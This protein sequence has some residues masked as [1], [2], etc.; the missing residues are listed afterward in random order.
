MYEMMCMKDDG[1]QRVEET[2]FALRRLP[3]T[4][5]IV[6]RRANMSKADWVVG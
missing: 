3:H 5:D 4:G 2:R 6:R 1:A